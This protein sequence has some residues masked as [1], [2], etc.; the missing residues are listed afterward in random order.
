MQKPMKNG[1]NVEIRNGKKKKKET[2]K[3]RGD[4]VLFINA[5]CQWWMEREITSI[6]WDSLVFRILIVGLLY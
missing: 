1:L 2:E 5:N 4:F 3:L 6:K